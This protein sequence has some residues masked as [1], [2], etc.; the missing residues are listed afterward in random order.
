[1]TCSW[2]LS[3]ARVWLCPNC[4]VELEGTVRWKAWLKCY[5]LDWAHA[6]RVQPV[7]YCC[8]IQV[9]PSPAEKITMWVALLK[10]ERKKERKKNHKKNGVIF[11]HVKAEQHAETRTR[12]FCL[13]VH[14][15]IV[16]ETTSWVEE[17]DFV[18]A[19]RVSR[20]VWAFELPGCRSVGSA[21]PVGSCREGRSA[22]PSKNSDHWRS[23]LLHGDAGCAKSQLGPSKQSVNWTTERTRKFDAEGLCSLCPIQGQHCICLCEQYGLGGCVHVCIFGKHKTEKG[24]H[25]NK[26]CCFVCSSGLSSLLICPLPWKSFIWTQNWRDSTMPRST[27]RSWCALSWDSLALLMHVSTHSSRSL[28]CC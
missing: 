16:R 13:S 15:T 5:A 14:I 1:M 6:L 28:L 2:G 21:S 7:C 19:N 23:F 9:A 26:C 12:T 17:Q 25:L 11:L 3:V 8:F 10:Q 18:E 27:E 24:L 4:L 22:A 20:N